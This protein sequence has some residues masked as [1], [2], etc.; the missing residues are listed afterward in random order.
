MID[1]GRLPTHILLLLQQQSLTG[2]DISKGMAESPVWRSSHQQVYRELTRLKDKGMLIHEVIPQT[3][4]PDKKVYSITPKGIECIEE[5]SLSRKPVIL[6]LH[7]MHTVMLNSGSSNYYQEYT[8]LLDI[9]I[10]LVT[11]KIKQ[12]SKSFNP[13]QEEL[14]AMKRER[15]IY[16]AEQQFCTDV[17]NEFATREAQAAA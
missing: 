15:Y 13:N 7:S 8:E 12:E 4:K 10:D 3:G 11:A 1:S 17:L 16:R 14:L 2:Y 9:E 6:P 5:I